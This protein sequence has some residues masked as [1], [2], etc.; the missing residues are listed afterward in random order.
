MIKTLIVYEIEFEG[1]TWQ[2]SRLDDFDNY[3]LLMGMSWECVEPS[4]KLKEY[5]KLYG[6]IG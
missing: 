1:E 5:V 3:M 4:E 6:F 2:T